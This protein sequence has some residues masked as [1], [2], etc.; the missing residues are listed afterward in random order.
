MN[1]DIIA[2]DLYRHYKGNIYRIV[3]VAID[4]ALLTYQVVYTDGRYTWVRSLTEFLSMV[5][6]GVDIQ[7]R[8]RRLTDNEMLEYFLSQKVTRGE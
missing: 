3:A 6:I 1:T 5:S 8:F 4:T 7:P 2:G